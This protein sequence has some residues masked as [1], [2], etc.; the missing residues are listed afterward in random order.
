MKKQ[1]SDIKEKND[2]KSSNSEEICEEKSSNPDENNETFG[3]IQANF[4]P[5]T[6]H[7]DLDKEKNQSIISI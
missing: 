2:K 5:K 7:I 3:E 1:N 4:S 6:P